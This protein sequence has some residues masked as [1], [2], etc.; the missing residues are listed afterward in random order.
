MNQRQIEGVCKRIN[1]AYAYLVNDDAEAALSPLLNSIDAVS[2]TG[3]SRFKDWVSK[4]MRVI[5]LCFFSLGGHSFGSV[6]IP[7]LQINKQMMKPDEVGTVPFEEAIYHL[8]RCSLVHNCA[9][10]EEIQDIR[11]TSYQ[12]DD[13]TGIMHLNLHRLA[14]GFLMALLVCIPEQ[15]ATRIQGDLNGYPLARL[16]GLSDA[17]MLTMLRSFWPAE[18]HHP[19]PT[20]VFMK[21]NPTV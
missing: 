13:D 21:H 16:C 18:S 19:S 9:L 12:Y 14:I 5:S 2:G 11:N 10:P 7:H 15:H 3:R 8:L 1:E 4:R 6:R 20:V 17:D